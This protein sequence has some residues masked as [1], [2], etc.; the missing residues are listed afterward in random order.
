[1]YFPFFK[2][3]EKKQLLQERVEMQMQETQLREHA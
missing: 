1:M 3:L 2:M